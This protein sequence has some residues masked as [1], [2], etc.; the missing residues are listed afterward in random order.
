MLAF[1]DDQDRCRQ[2]FSDAN[3]KVRVAACTIPQGR[4][5]VAVLDENQ[6]PVTE[7]AT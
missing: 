2:E 1:T 7:F 3:G 6:N 4:M 5:G